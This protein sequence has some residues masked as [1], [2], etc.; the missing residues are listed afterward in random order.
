MTEN[1]N[2]IISAFIVASFF[3]LLIL[4]P[5]PTLAQESDLEAENGQSADLDEI[6]G[7]SDPTKPVAF[8]FREEFYDLKGDAWQNV[9]ILRADQLILD[10]KELLGHRRGVIL[11]ADIPLVSYHGGGSTRTGLG[12]LYGQALLIPRVTGNFMLAFGTGF[13]F[14]TATGDE[15]GRGKWIVSPIAVPIWFFP[16]Q[17]YAYI[18]VQDWVSFEGDSGRPDVHYLTVTPTFLWRLSKRYWMML[19]G[20]SST[21]WET[22]NRTNYKGGLLIGRMFSKKSGLS[23]KAE[24]PF[25]EHRQGDWTVKAV[26]FITRY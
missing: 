8:S 20:E 10:K 5:S 22:N 15:F 1:R 16:H 4:A 21:N 3:M 12:D 24:V 17:G 2:Q 26:F 18:K 11:R 13:T 25:G 23:L 9:V 14:P 6:G 7:D 19:D